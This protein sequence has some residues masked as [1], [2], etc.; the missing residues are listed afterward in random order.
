M[1]SPVS[2]SPA[3]LGSITRI[4]VITIASIGFLFDTYEL[5]MFP[6]IGSNAIAELQY[7]KKVTSLS[8]DEEESVQLWAGRMQ[9]I[10]ALSGGGLGLLGGLLIDRLGRKFTMIGAILA[11]SFSPVAAAF[12]SALWQL[13]LFRCTTFMGVC[14][15]DGR[16]ACLPGSGGAFRR[17]AHPRAGDR[18]DAGDSVAGRFVRH[19]GVQFHRRGRSRRHAADVAIPGRPY[20]GERGVAL[21]FAYRL[22]SGR[23]DTGLDAV[24]SRIGDLETQKLEGTLE[25]RR[26]SARCLPA[27]FAARRS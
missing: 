22:D 4:L 3:S 10:A 23:D 14:V 6:V 17:Q 2:V 15:E 11:Y 21:H 12:S 27:I 19:A 26:A 7:G 1:S 24:R 16:M 9:W 25:A 13:I 8:P 20:A 18:L 5:L